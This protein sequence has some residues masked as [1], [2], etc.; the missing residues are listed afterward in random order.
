MQLKL[1]NRYVNSLG[2]ACF[3]SHLE[4]GLMH[5]TYLGESSYT[6]PW[7]RK[8]FLQEVKNNRFF[9]QPKPKITRENI[10]THLIEYQL[11]MIGKT[12][13]DVKD[14]EQWYHNNTFTQIQYEL[15]KEYA[16]SLIK[17]TFKC[18][19]KKAEQTFGWFN[20]NYGLRLQI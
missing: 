8:E 4:R 12:I 16:V 14:D 17:K 10:Q 6:E 15:F 20:L 5:L 2:K 18:N 9:P 13:N 7:G 11:N 1:G 3:I 19:T